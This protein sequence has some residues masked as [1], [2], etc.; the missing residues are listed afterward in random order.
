MDKSSSNSVANGRFRYIHDKEKGP[1][2]AIDIHHIIVQRNKIK[3]FILRFSALL[4]LASPSFLFVLQVQRWSIRTLILSSELVFPFFFNLY[5]HSKKY[6]SVQCSY[7]NVAKFYAL[8]TCNSG[9]CISCF[10]V[11][12]NLMPLILVILGCAYFSKRVMSF[13]LISLLQVKWT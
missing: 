2:E 11:L 4:L 13:A 6:G 3:G 7:V 9:L 10:V 1:P 8:N 5:F 12:A